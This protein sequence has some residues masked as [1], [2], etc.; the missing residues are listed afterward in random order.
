MGSVQGHGGIGLSEHGDVELAEF[1][2]RGAFSVAP[3][4][5]ELRARGPESALRNAAPC[6]GGGPLRNA[7]PRPGGG[8]LRDHG[9]GDG[10][11]KIDLRWGF[12]EVDAAGRADSLD[13]AAEGRQI[14]I[15]FQD[16]ALGV[17]RLQPQSRGGL[18]QLTGGGSGI[19]VV[20]QPGQLHGEGGTALAAL[21]QPGA[22]RGADQRDGIDAGMPVEPSVFLEPECAGQDGG[23]FVPGGPQAVLAIGGQGCAEELAVGGPDGGGLRRQVAERP[24]RVDA[25][26]EKDCGQESDPARNSGAPGHRG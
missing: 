23:H 9:K 2:I 7:A 16:A 19:Q 14:Q 26:E 17:A 4:V 25:N 13:V 22:A 6:P 12:A 20:Y 3:G 24:V 18:L 5:D 21:A 10:F 8:P 15:G 11:A 1:G